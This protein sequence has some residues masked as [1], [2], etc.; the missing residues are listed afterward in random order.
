MMVAD[1]IHARVLSINSVRVDSD[2]L[3]R[4]LDSMD[5]LSGDVSRNRRQSH[6]FRWRVRN[7]LIFPVQNDRSIV[8]IVPT[9]NLSVEG[10]SFLHGQMMHV[11]RTVGVQL[12]MRGRGWLRVN[13][14]V[15]RCRHVRAMVHEV[16]LHF[17]NLIDLQRLCGGRAVV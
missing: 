7:A 17:E 5:R 16:G 11:G 12:P 6:R 10:M 8:F 14:T 13:G 3:M 9:R 4:I 2:M 1:S 15:V